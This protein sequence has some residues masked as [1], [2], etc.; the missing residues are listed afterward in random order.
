LKI[1]CA[2]TAKAAMTKKLMEDLGLVAVDPGV[3]SDW[4]VVVINLDFDDSGDSVHSAYVFTIFFSD[5]TARSGRSAISRP[6]D[7]S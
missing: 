6:D 3:N 4:V 5:L 2:T 1:K 7:V